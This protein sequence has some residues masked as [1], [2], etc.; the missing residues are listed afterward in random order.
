VS[1][2]NKHPPGM[3]EWAI[4]DDGKDHS[5]RWRRI[6]YGR[7]VRDNSAAVSASVREV[8]L[9]EKLRNVVTTY[10]QRLHCSV[11]FRRGH[12]EC[13]RGVVTDLQKLLTDYNHPARPEAV[14]V[15]MKR[16]GLVS[17]ADVMGLN[18]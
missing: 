2:N 15:T 14:R 5:E 9:R 16:D 17:V 10:Q 3:D 18:D 7:E 11:E 4:P 12:V 6:I 8:S 13:L 1:D